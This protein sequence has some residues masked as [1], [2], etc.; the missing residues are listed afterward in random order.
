M[1]NK[2]HFQHCLAFAAMAIFMLLPGLGFGQLLLVDDFTGLNVGVPLAGQS[3]W[4]KFGSGPDATI[5][6]ATALT[7]ANYNGGGAE[8][9]IM[10][11]GASATSK[12]YKALGSTPA[13]GT[14]TFYYSLL[15]R[16]TAT[17]TPS[18]NYFMS[19]GDPATGTT[20]FARLFA[21]TS[22]AG[23][24][25][26]ISKLSNTAIYGST[27][28]NLNQTYLIVVRY[29]FVT[30]TTNDL[31]YIWVNPSLATEPSTA[32]AEASN[33]SGNDG[34][35]A[36]VGNFLWHN[37][38]ITNPAGSFDGIR[39]AYGATSAEAWTNLA[40]FAGNP[41][42]TNVNFT[43]V[44]FSDLTANWTNGTG[45]NRA[46]F[47]KQANTGTASP[48][49]NTTYTAS[50]TFGSG[51]Q[52][53]TTGWFCIYNGTGSTVNVTG[54]A[55]LTDYIVMV[56]EYTGL[57]GAEQYNT[58]PATGNP[59]TVTTLAPASPVLTATEPNG[60]GNVCISAMGGPESFTIDGVYLTTANITVAALD[61]FTYSTTAGG[62]YTST[63]SLPQPGG[64]YSQDIFVKV[65]PNPCTTL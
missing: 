65:F 2:L 39:V 10:P 30:G 9:V 64:T 52:I 53:G 45:T 16:L 56:C 46:V 54:L 6:N 12:V 1:K 14:N 19:L 49:N 50:T 55:A 60:F 29:D 15:L 34:T 18:G 58:T 51:T 41:Q 21:Q 40:A 44:T 24:N 22:G 17:T 47:M 20:Y 8:Y 32:S 23:F 37:R 38:G 61:G 28:L 27:V 3:G 35:P 62:T 63:L 36:T 42:A 43:N 13:P 31:I 5:G 7:Y 59:N 26:G 57:A 48:V 11:T 33:S 4:T 25:I